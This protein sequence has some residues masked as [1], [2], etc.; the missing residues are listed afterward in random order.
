[1]SSSSKTTSVTVYTT[2]YG[3]IGPQGPLGPMGPTGPIG[4][5]GLSTL[6]GVS[7]TQTGTGAVTRSIDSKLKDFISV[8]DFG[9]VGN[10]I[11]D[12]TLAIKTALQA[13]SNKTL[14]FPEGIYSLQSFL[15]TSRRNMVVFF[16]GDTKLIGNNALLRCDTPTPASHMLYL[17][18]NGHDVYCEGLILDG[19]NKSVYGLR[20]DENNQNISS[21][22][23]KNCTIT[24][25]YSPFNAYGSGVGGVCGWIESTGLM[26]YGAWYNI[27]VDG[28]I[29]K[30]ISRAQGAGIPGTAGSCGILLTSGISGSS[31]VPYKTAVVSN[32]YIENV[33][34][35]EISGPSNID[36]DGLKIF[37]GNTTGTAYIP[38]SAIIYGNRF[39]N[40]RGRDIKVQNDESIIQN[41]ISHFNILPIKN[42]GTRINC[43][44]TSG[45]VSNN[46]FHYDV[47]AGNLSPFSE[48]GTTGGTVGEG[49]V[50]SFYDGQS[51][52][53]PRVITVNDNHVFNNVP[54]NIGIL[55]S[56]FDG[57]ALA[58]SS[59]YPIFG[60]IKGNKVAGG[61][62]KYFS[63]LSLKNTGATA[64]YSI[65][66]NMVSKLQVS[67]MSANNGGSFDKTII[68][69]SGNRNSG[70]AVKHMVASWDFPN[71]SIY[72]GNI[73]GYNNS[74]IGLTAAFQRNEQAA[75]LSRFDSLGDINSQNGGVISV[76]SA[77]I[78]N[79]QIYNF[80][81]KG[82]Y[83]YGR[84]C[85]LTAGIDERANFM[86]IHGSNA[87]VGMT[88]GSLIS[89]AN[90][91]NPDV[92][93]KINLWCSSSQVI[94]LK[95]RFGS[96]A[97]F[98][99]FSFG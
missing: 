48:T 65:D 54:E 20:F 98:T 99:L 60:T 71:Y 7:F 45:I 59:Q 76:Q 44:I 18:A 5:T 6:A 25:C 89:Y 96:T 85:M 22:T 16:T 67:F 49:N 92:A 38:N 86:F 74:N 75:F 62:L 88:S 68:S 17:V 93:G 31:Y 21:I 11:A 97:V 78:A 37:G 64:Y 34:S 47:T 66:D 27:L 51:D 36:A 58:Y 42:G 33:T 84:F 95:N 29:V 28:C 53:R 3:V 81:I 39:I 87:I 55:R 13:A 8:K 56:F 41:N 52:E 83:G 57:T 73:S 19:N 70:P 82:Y 43:Q 35:E 72:G 69:A 90:T 77:T 63:E 50:I 91:T 12:D 24:N 79:D 46:I 23:V 94:S 30:N 15:D 4:A 80:P 1:M 9:A 10:G 61:L 2:P 32:C 26:L 40:C 14:Y